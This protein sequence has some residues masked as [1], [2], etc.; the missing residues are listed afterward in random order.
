[1][2]IVARMMTIQKPRAIFE[3]RRAHL[4][5]CEVGASMSLKVWHSGQSVRKNLVAGSW[6]MGCWFRL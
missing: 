1:M 2:A 6:R 4:C 5:D 3:R